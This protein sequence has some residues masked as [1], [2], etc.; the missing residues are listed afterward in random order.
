VEIDHLSRLGASSYSGGPSATAQRLFGLPPTGVLGGPPSSSTALR[1]CR[2]IRYPINLQNERR[3]MELLLDITGCALSKY[4]TSLAQ[5]TSDLLD[6]VA[7]PKYSNKRN[8]KLQVWGEKEVLHH[9]ALWARTAMHVIDI[10]LHELSEE[11]K[12]VL[13]SKGIGA[14]NVAAGASYNEELGYDYVIQA[15]E[16]DDD[17]HFT[18]LRYC[19]D[20]LGAIR[21]DEMASIH[22]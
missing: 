1:T 9:F 6:E 22:Y 2:D 18:I 3:A 13:S 21:R 8:A 7:Y 17:C 12:L 10:I 11:R 14:C 20:V 16:E 15:M 5:D 19:S 4:P